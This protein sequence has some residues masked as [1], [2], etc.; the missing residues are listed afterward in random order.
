MKKRVLL[1]LCIALMSA[2]SF[3][4]TAGNAKKDTQA[5]GDSVAFAQALHYLETMDFIIVPTSIEVPGYGAN[6]TPNQMANFVCANDG[7]G[8]IQII[9][10][11]STSAGQNGMGGITAEGP[12][13]ISRQRTDKKG[14]VTIEYNV[15]GKASA[16]V[17][18]TLP[19]NGTN[20]TV[21]ISSNNV[22]G[23]VR[24]NGNVVKFD[25]N[26]ISIGSAIDNTGSKTGRF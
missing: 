26:S 14:N 5:Q 8:V 18:V 2:V 10:E 19:K 3:N 22:Q 15:M 4:A 25:P 1:A 20:A 17:R 21:R 16:T 11:F 6:F 12:I 7:K 24:M 23:A 13:K 9:P